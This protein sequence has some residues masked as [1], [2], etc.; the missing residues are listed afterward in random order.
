[1]NR[2]KSFALGHKRRASIARKKR[3][4]RLALGSGTTGRV[5]APKPTMRGEGVTHARPMGIFGRL[6]AMAEELLHHVEDDVVPEVVPAVVTAKAEVF[7]FQAYLDAEELRADRAFEKQSND[8]RTFSECL[9]AA[10]DRGERLDVAMSRLTKSYPWQREAFDASSES[11]SMGGL[12]LQAVAAIAEDENLPYPQALAEA[13]KRFP[14]A[15]MDY[16]SGGR[17]WADEVARQK[18]GE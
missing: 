15:A 12:F 6:Q 16:A 11:V 5:T 2:Y 4:S 3:M 10:V 14:A 7:N 13:E 1:M 8:A 17:V 18:V 9:R